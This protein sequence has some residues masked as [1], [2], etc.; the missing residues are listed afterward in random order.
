M[1]PGWHAPAVRLCSTPTPC[2]APGLGRALLIALLFYSIGSFFL[3]FSVYL[4]DALHVTAVTGGPRLPAVWC[5]IPAR[6]AVD[7]LSPTILR[8][9]C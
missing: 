6:A 3:L 5:R 2:R 8:R 1:R 7:A 4:Q 9:L